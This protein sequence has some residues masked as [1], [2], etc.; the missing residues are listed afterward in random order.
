[1]HPFLPKNF[2]PGFSVRPPSL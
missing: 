2:L 1:M